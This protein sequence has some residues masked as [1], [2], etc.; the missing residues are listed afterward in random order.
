MLG[1]WYQYNLEQFVYS[2]RHQTILLLSSLPGFKAAQF[3]EKK[4]H[5]LWY[6]WCL[7]QFDC[8]SSSLAKSARS[9]SYYLHS[10]SRIKSFGTMR[11]ISFA[12]FRS[13]RATIFST[14]SHILDCLVGPLTLSC[15]CATR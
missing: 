13:N 2:E 15:L 9:A 10:R 5:L 6:F 4:T 12:I 1:S 8:S 3:I 7:P 14:S 11:T